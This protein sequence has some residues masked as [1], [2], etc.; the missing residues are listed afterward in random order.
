M[1]V[2][3]LRVYIVNFNVMIVYINLMYYYEIMCTLIVLSV[4]NY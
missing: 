2:S 4:K 3:V 1:Y